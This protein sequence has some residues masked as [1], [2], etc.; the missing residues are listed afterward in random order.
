MLN[1]LGKI[2]IILLLL[3][4]LLLFKKFALFNDWLDTDVAA[5]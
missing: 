5:E 2:I 3:L 4:L 1:T